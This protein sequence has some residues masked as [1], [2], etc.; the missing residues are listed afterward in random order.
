MNQK[1]LMCL[2]LLSFGLLGLMGTAASA[3]PLQPATDDQIKEMVAAAG[4]AEDYKGASVLYVLDEADVFVQDS[5]LATTKTCQ[6]I[7]VLTD[8]GIRSQS[9][10]RLDYDPDTRRVVLDSVRIHRKGGEIE[11]VSLSD[12]VT[13]PTQQH[14]I[15]WGG[16]QHLLSIPRLAVGDC[17]EIRTSK[18]GFNIAYLGADGNPL[19]SMAGSENLQPPMEGHWYE[20]MLFQANHPITKK[21]YAVH[22]PKDKPVQY[23]VY[24]GELKTSLWF[25]GDFHVYTFSDEDIPAVARE[26]RMEAL[27]DCVTKVVMATVPDWETK[28]RWFYE[29]NEPQFEADDAIRAKVAELTEGIEDEEEKILACLH[30]SADK[31]RYYGTSRG[32]CEGFTLHESIETFHDRGGVCKDK[33]GMMVT[34]MRV[35][36]HEVYPALTMAG[37]RVERI[38]ADQFNHTVTVQRKKDGSFRILDPTWVPMSREVW[39]SRESLQGLV[40]G[41]PEGQDLTLSPYYTPEY[42][43]LWM[44]S[45]S[46]I[47]TDGS[48]ATQIHVDTA[49]YADTYLRRSTARYP[50]EEQKAAFEH[51]LNIAPNAKLTDLSFTDVFDYADNGV[52]DMAVEADGYAAGE[53]EMRMFRLPLMSHP[54]SNFFIPDFFY[55]VDID[56]RQFSM[57]LRATRLVHYEEA[58]KLPAGWKIEHLPEKQ[59][60]DSGS[61]KLTF[62]ATEKD[63]VLTYVFEFALKN[64]NVPAEDYVE[65]KKSIDTMNE[66][67][68]AWVVCSVN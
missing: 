16:L 11:D 1:V 36:G 3:E 50:V 4:D 51:A 62:E 37:S 26:P 9:V 52:V 53:G 59:S 13:Q 28:S 22:M 20:V 67:T 66:I 6:V 44:R 58:I 55:P 56:E 29:V 63:G 24:N 23:E 42:N 54:L 33:A 19:H 61:A 27:D 38:P 14:W 46:E 47:K 45:E 35:L 49:G 5:G 10:L 12:V 41:T 57:R 68:D 64:Q 60:L 30:W 39:S 48:L 31:V 17:L 43:G 7:K 21:R 34:M 40:Y 25:D 8:A 18:I 2:W 15:Y 32:P 65:Y